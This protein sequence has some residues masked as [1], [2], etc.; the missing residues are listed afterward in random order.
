MSWAVSKSSVTVASR[1]A[2]LPPLAVTSQVVSPVSLTAAT[3]TVGLPMPV[4]PTVKSVRSTLLTASLNTTR[5]TRV[6]ALVLP[7]LCMLRRVM[8]VTVGAVVSLGVAVA[9][10]AAPS[11]A[12]FTA[13]TWKLY[14]VPLVRLLM[15]ALVSSV[16]SLSPSLSATSVQPPQ[17]EALLTLYRYWYL[18]N[19]AVPPLSLGA[20][21]FSVT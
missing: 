6:S 2:R 17:F 4:P 19:A 7:P 20:L 12:L 13:R 18:V 8:E 9:L 11:P 14:A 16:T 5:H 3:A 1:L 21:Q 10:A 15:V